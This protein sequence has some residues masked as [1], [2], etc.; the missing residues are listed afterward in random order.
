MIITKSSYKDI[1][2]VELKTAELTVLVL[3]HNGG[4]IASIKNN[5]SG[6]EYLVQNPNPKYSP[7][8]INGSF[9]K[10]ECSGF[11]DMFPTIDGITFT[12]AY[13]RELTYPDH[14][15]VCRVK[16]EYKID[17]D[18]LTLYYKSN[19]LNY[20]HTK[21]FFEKDGKLSIEYAVENFADCDFN[22]LWAGHLL[23]NAEQGGRVLL[24]FK[25]GSPVDVT[26]DFTGRF[27]AGDRIEYKEEYLKSVWEKGVP[28][29]KKLY[30][31][32]PAPQGY[33]AYEYPNGDIFVMEFDKNQL[34]YIGIWENLGHL[35]GQYCLG[36]E[37]CSVGY[38]TVI[39]GEKKGQSRPIKAGETMRFYINLLVK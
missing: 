5:K 9:E 31:P 36:L 19:A 28:A 34:P 26:F 39:N 24:P 11:D 22:A 14:G 2:A 6:R 16:H 17:G 15:E 35:N 27:K 4:K 12:D 21:T 18:R 20:S 3:P 25:D 38:D 29:C 30:F 32:L 8:D 7:L 10:T 1:F 13:G 37:P 33:I 23:I